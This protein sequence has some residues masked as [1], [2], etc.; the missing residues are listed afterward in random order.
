M[1]PPDH[2]MDGDPIDHH[3]DDEA[4]DDGDG[5]RAVRRQPSADAKKYKANMPSTIMA[6]CVRLITFMTPQISV[7]P[8]AARP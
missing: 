6:P 1:R 2:A 3:T 7:S 4:D 8:M 5:H